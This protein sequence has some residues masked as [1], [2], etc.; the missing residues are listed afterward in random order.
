MIV[1][2]K[3]LH[4]GSPGQ[5]AW[6]KE[7]KMKNPNLETNHRPRAMLPGVGSD[8][9]IAIVERPLE[10]AD[11]GVPLGELLEMRGRCRA[12]G[13][14]LS[15]EPTKAK[16]RTSGTAPATGSYVYARSA[17]WNMESINSQIHICAEMIR[18]SGQRV[19]A[20]FAD[21]GASGNAIGDG[22]RELLGA[23]RQGRVTQLVVADR[24]RLGRPLELFVSI[25]ETLLACGVLVSFADARR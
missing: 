12:I 23:A 2:S 25:L 5:P 11:N 13:P 8:G 22:L 9:Q 21:N 1:G 16:A 14:S 17:V 3:K 20:V 4:C 10:I 15:N 24:D 18:E 7:T 6:E 19:Q